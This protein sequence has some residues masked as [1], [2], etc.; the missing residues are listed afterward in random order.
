MLSRCPPPKFYPWYN[1]FNEIY[2][3]RQIIWWILKIRIKFRF[4][5]IDMMIAE[6]FNLI[7]MVFKKNCLAVT[8]KN[9]AIAKSSIF[10]SLVTRFWSTFVSGA[11]NRFVLFY[12]WAFLKIFNFISAFTK[13]FKRIFYL[14]RH[15][16]GFFHL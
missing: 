15:F 14:S 16:C 4:Y 11:E 5:R 2:R 1:D 10:C 7:T 8:K 6:D 12:I 9:F 13:V 3:V